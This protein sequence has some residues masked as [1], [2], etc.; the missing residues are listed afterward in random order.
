MPPA[1][2]VKTRRLHARTARDRVP[3]RRHDGARAG[4]AGARPD[5]R[6]QRACADVMFHA[7]WTRVITNG[8][9]RSKS[10]A[11]PTSLVRPAAHRR[12]QRAFRIA[13]DGGAD[14][15]GG[16]D[17]WRHHR[18]WPRAAHFAA[19]SYTALGEPLPHRPAGSSRRSWRS[20]AHLHL[21]WTASVLV[22]FVERNQFATPGCLAKGARIGTARRTNWVR[23]RRARSTATA[24]R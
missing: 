10:R 11:R 22:N 1:R 17:P 15:V 14:L 13:P 24:Q 23:T 9:S 19:N 2:R 20:R 21:A 4:S 18:R 5:A 16:A 8:Y 3:I 6:R 7:F 12:D